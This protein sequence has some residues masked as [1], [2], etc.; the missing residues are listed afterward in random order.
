M[1]DTIGEKI[2]GNY[3]YFGRRLVHEMI[4]AVRIYPGRRSERIIA[5]R[6]LS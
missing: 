5:D 4:N 6:T 2:H 1:R 3:N